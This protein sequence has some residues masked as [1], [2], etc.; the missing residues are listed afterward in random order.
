MKY[1]PL[2]LIFFSG[3]AQAQDST[4]VRRYSSALEI[5]EKLKF[6]DKA[7]KFKELISDSRCPKEVTCIWAGEAKMLVEIY[8]K[9]KLRGEKVLVIAGGGNISTSFNELFS[10]NAFSLSGLVLDPYPSAVTAV[11]PSEYRLMLEVKET[12]KH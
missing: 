7:I 6:G 4:T 9:G 8:E 11:D 3:F 1:L 2:F 5:G 12:V 10:E